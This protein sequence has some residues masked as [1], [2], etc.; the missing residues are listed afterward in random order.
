L[1]GGKESGIIDLPSAITPGLPE[2][3]LI[4]KQDPDLDVDANLNELTVSVGKEP[5][6]GVLIRQY[7]SN[8]EEIDEL[9]LAWSEV[10]AGH[11]RRLKN[12][13]ISNS[14]LQYQNSRLPV[15][16]FYGINTRIINLTREVGELFLDD[17]SGNLPEAIANISLHELG[18][19]Y[20]EYLFDDKSIEYKNFDIIFNDLKKNRLMKTAS[21]YNKK[22]FFADLYRSYLIN[23]ELI[24]YVEKIKSIGLPSLKKVFESIFKEEQE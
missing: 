17:F 8:Q 11:F 6:A 9:R 24:E 20:Y 14:V 4:I 13:E 19:H 12:V 15:N 3:D 21:W 18:H 5:H 22:E 2:K 1:K 10:P 23:K 16:G 7:N